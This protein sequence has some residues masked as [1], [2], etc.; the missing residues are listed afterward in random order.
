[1]NKGVI[2]LRDKAQNAL[3]IC[4]ESELLESTQNMLRSRDGT[5][6]IQVSQDLNRRVR[7]LS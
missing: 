5:S 2:L 1:M 4:C 7:L 3:Q 6:C